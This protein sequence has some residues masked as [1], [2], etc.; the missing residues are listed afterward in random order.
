M[1]GGQQN[2]ENTTVNGPLNQVQNIYI[3]REGAEDAA[4]RRLAASVDAR[5]AQETA[6]RSLWL[7]DPLV[8]QVRSTERPVQAPVPAQL[9]LAGDSDGIA[10]VFHESPS[11]QMAIIGEPGAG[12]TVLALLLVRDLLPEPG[13]RGPVPVFLSLASWHP[14]VPLKTWM[15][16]RIQED[17]PDIADNRSAGRES[18]LKLIEERRILPVLDGLDEVPAAS[19]EAV[20]A[21]IGTAFDDRAPFVVTSRRKEYVDAVEA[22][23]TALAR[24][25]VVEV[26]AVEVEDAIAYLGGAVTDD[27]RWCPLFDRLRAAPDGPLARALS[28]PLMLFLAQTA[29][30]GPAT[31]PEELLAY[32]DVESIEE[33]LLDTFVPATYARHLSPSYAEHRAKRW[34]GTLARGPAEYRWWHLRSSVADTAAGLV[35]ALGTGWMLWLMLDAVWA[36]TGAACVLLVV[37]FCSRL[38]INT[39]NEIV[40]S[41]RETADLRAHLRRYGTLALLCAALTAILVGAVMGIWVGVVLD[42]DPGTTIAYAGAYGAS[43]GMAAL[44]STAWGKYKLRHYSLAA[45]GLLPFWLVRFIENAHERGVLRKPG[46]FYQFRHVRLQGR[47]RGNGADLLADQPYEIVRAEASALQVFSA[48]LTVSVYRLLGHLFAV[49]TTALVLSMFS[50]RAFMAYESGTRPEQYEVAVGGGGGSS[51]VPVPVWRWTIPP[52]TGPVTSAYSVPRHRF[53]W[54]YQEFG[55]YVEVTGCEGASIVMTT[56]TSASGSPQTHVLD[57]G[58]G[59]QLESLNW[60]LPDH[61]DRVSFAFRRLDRAP[62]TALVD[63]QSPMLMADQLFGIRRHFD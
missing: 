45:Q 13:A 34:L 40:V 16:T 14:D 4:A 30:R 31:S 58:H 53:G 21:G 56:T 26:A 6:R 36:V 59:T 10:D 46:A 49:V 51:S 1:A 15:A 19:P 52:G 18:A 61:F 22:S 3:G 55:G 11:R 50:E 35:F 47:L 33:H 9:R 38:V 20:I 60:R 57:T 12:K 54:P 27:R 41:E 39:R 23:G 24:A 2:I 17:H 44:I 43:F 62:C 42:A 37:E 63:W 28:T 5:V 48:Q 29:Y 8:L 25:A 7:S 32:T